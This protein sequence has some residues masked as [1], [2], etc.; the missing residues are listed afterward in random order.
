MNRLQL[1][2]KAIENSFDGVFI[3]DNKGKVLYVNKAY[4]KLAQRGRECFV[5]RYMDQLIDEGLMKLYISKEVIESGK[6]ITRAENLLSGTEVIVTSTPVFDEEEKVI[7]AVTN[8]RDISEIIRLQEENICYRESLRYNTVEDKVVAVS[9]VTKELLRTAKKIAQ[10]H[11]T[12]LITGETGT[13]KEV[14]ADYI[15]SN[16]QRNEKPFVRINC[17][18]ISPTLIESELFGYVKGAFTGA[19]EK[20]KKGAFEIADG[21]TIFLDEIGELPLDMQVKFLR[22]LQEGELTRIGAERSQKVDVRVI[23]ATNRNLKQMVQ[24]KTF[25]EDLYYRI[26]VLTLELAPL[27]ERIEDIPD[28]TRLFINQLNEKYG[29]QKE[30]TSHFLEGLMERPWPGNVRELSN[31]VEQQYV[32][33]DSGVLHSFASLKKQKEAAPAAKTA[34]QVEAAELPSLY[35][36]V[37][38][39]EKDLVLKA[40]KQGRTTHEAAKLLGISQPTFSR[41]Y[42]KYKE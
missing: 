11:S 4:E 39:L 30:A 16:S 5:G 34:D 38:E 7:A 41:K 32:I 3:V 37:E 33:N 27:R 42:N 22:V 18:A 1:L 14:F 9:P 10:K 26:S 35:A 23:A 13:G 6:S 19:S 25:R 2:E 28:L 29:G 17:G 12:V 31:F 8:V 36:A 20:G 21:G 24:E 40:M 15:F